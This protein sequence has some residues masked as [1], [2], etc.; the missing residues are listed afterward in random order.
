MVI[1]VIL[2]VLVLAAICGSIAMLFENKDRD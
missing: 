1:V 2:V